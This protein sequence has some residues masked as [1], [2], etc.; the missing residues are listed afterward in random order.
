MA[1]T[2][3]T[4]LVVSVWYHTTPYISY[5]NWCQVVVQAHFTFT[6]IF[7]GLIWFVFPTSLIV[8]NDIAAYFMGFTFGKKLINRPLL[9]LSPNKTWEGFVGAAFWTV[10]VGYYVS[11]SD[12][13]VL[14]NK[15]SLMWNFRAQE[16][17]ANTI[18]WRV[19]A[20]TPRSVP[21]L[22]SSN[23]PKF[24]SPALFKLC[25]AQYVIYVC[26]LTTSY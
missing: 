16:R 13:T 7:E 12:S 5:T 6:M 3:T 10:V 18:G 15:A 22:H 1:W 11:E 25:C 20:R 2:I 17:W 23:A 26:L 8:F 19:Q 14:P 21:R 9:K 4:L 24:T